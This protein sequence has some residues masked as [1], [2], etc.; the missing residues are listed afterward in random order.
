MKL[1]EFFSFNFKLRQ[2]LNKSL[3]WIPK[4]EYFSEAKTW[5]Q[6]FGCRLTIFQDYDH[7]TLLR[8]LNYYL[9]VSQ[10][11]CRVNSFGFKIFK[12]INLQLIRIKTKI[13]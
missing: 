10:V 8:F 13:L 3:F 6:G 1:G 9:V 4:A 7:K 2:I 11:Q 12:C 5:V